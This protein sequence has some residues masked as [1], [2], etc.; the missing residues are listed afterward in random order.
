MTIENQ[1][2]PPPNASGDALRHGPPASLLE[3]DLPGEVA[4][5]SIPDTPVLSDDLDEGTA[6]HE[7]EA[8]NAEVRAEADLDASE[9]ISRAAFSAPPDASVSA[10]ETAHRVAQ[11]DGSETERADASVAEPKTL[12]RWL[13][14]GDSHRRDELAGRFACG[15]ALMASYGLGLSVTGGH[16]IRHILGVPSAALA[17][18]AI[19]APSLFIAL[20]LF[21]VPIDLRAMLRANASAIATLGAIL[22]GLTPA[23]TLFGLT[24]GP[25]SA[26]FVAAVGLVLGSVVAAHRFVR[27]VTAET[28]DSAT[29]VM[30]W[31]V[32]GG[33]LFFTAVLSLRV[34]MF[35]LPIFGGA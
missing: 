31:L 4:V 8:E 16:P 6:E 23:I 17:V 13:L 29:T 1:A 25:G 14:Y 24:S 35:T 11:A 3:D 12:T 7:R 5:S 15:L 10:I 22:A 30:S 33:F 20:S 32:C 18:L 2:T 26:I 19:G 21:N 27:D 34:W 28:H 9:E